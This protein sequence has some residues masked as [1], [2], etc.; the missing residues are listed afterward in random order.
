MNQSEK[1]QKIKK[2]IDFRFL[3]ERVVFSVVWFVN[4]F[5]LLRILFHLL[6]ANTDTPFIQWLYGVSS[7]F[8]T[9]FIGILPSPAIGQSSALDS[10][11]IV[12][13]IMYFVAAIALVKLINI[14]R[15]TIKRR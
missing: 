14:G 11:S 10:A 7:I 4:A 5:L 6:G 3:L 9:P 15:G 12:A 8:V 13:I 2:E 1:P